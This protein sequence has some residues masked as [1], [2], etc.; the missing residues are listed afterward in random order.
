[1]FADRLEKRSFKLPENSVTRSDEYTDIGD[2]NLSVKDH[3]PTAIFKSIDALT[4]NKEN[5]APPMQPQHVNITNTSSIKSDQT[6]NLEFNG[7]HFVAPMTTSV[8]CL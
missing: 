3:I 2:P 7:T 8:A 5:N 6:P 4:H 1:M